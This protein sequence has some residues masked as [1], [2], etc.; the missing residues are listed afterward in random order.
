MKKRMIIV[1]PFHFFLNFVTEKSC[2]SFTT[3][4][5]SWTTKINLWQIMPPADCDNAICWK[6]QSYLLTTAML[7]GGGST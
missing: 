7:S 1:W 2:L 4:S 6:Q 3:A 5:G